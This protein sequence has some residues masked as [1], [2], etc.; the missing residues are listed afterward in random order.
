MAESCGGIIP[1]IVIVTMAG[2]SCAGGQS[3]REFE[4]ASVKLNH[5]GNSSS[6]EH[7]GPGRLTITNDTLKD[8]LR[9]AYDVKDFQ[10]E[11]GP[12][13]L[14]S[15][16][17]DIVATT[18]RS[19]AITNQQLRPLLQALLA[20]RFHLKTHR[21]TRDM[22]VYSL[23]VAKNGPKLTAHTGG[24]GGDSHT[25]NASTGN[26]TG[27]NATMATLANSLSQVTGRPVSDKTAI[28][29]RFDYRI[30]WVPDQTDSSGP[31]I[32]TAVQEQLGLRLDSTKGPVEMLV[33]DSAEKASEN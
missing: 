12:R 5:S 14:D 3:I 30:V 23:V 27:T 1:R 26:I 10:I 8:L 18:G 4:V 22:I 20:D 33:I 17:Y 13:W 32:F 28:E 24:G 15:D 31:S 6:G 16:R 2:L 7:T 29:G 11:G 21:E 19:E 25:T 9:V